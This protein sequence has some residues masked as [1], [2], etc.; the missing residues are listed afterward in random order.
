MCRPDRSNTVAFILPS[1]HSPAIIRKTTMSYSSPFSK[2]AGTGHLVSARR[3]AADAQMNCKNH[4]RSLQIRA[5][6][7]RVRDSQPGCRMCVC[8]CVGR[9][10]FESPRNMRKRCSGRSRSSNHWSP[11]HSL[12][13]AKMQSGDDFRRGKSAQQSVHLEK[14]ATSQGHVGLAPVACGHGAEDQRSTLPRCFVSNPLMA[15]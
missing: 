9:M 8:R 1:N 10:R 15:P 13:A 6:K 7:K 2:M 11:G 5:Q 4:A 14:I 12:I 3:G